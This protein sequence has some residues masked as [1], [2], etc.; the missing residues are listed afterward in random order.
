MLEKSDLELNLNRVHEWIKAADQKVSI[1]LAFQGVVLAILFPSV[2]SWVIR[3][4]KNIPFMLQSLLIV[5]II[6]IAY[7]IYK[8]A[9]SIIPRLSKDEKKSLTYFGDIA[10][11]KIEEFKRAI[12]ELGEKEYEEELIEQIQI[13]SIIAKR[14]HS[15]FRSALII[16]FGGL[17]LCALSYL[18]FKIF[19][20]N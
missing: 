5:G 9:M 4:W 2:F 17:F 1:F 13:S 16:F 3:H 19:Y 20:G 11:F 18:S 10:E 6:L 15:Q 7:S 8:S 14:K 12:E